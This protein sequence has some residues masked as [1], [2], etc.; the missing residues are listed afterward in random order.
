MTVTAGPDRGKTFVVQGP[1]ARLG[2]DVTCEMCLTDT[3]IS[4]CHGT[5]ERTIG[6]GVVI[7]SDHSRNG[8]YYVQRNSTQ[9]TSTSES[10]EAIVVP[11]QCVCVILFYFLRQLTK[12][13]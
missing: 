5:V 12:A 4:R 8:T 7:F 1:Y 9:P 10:V 2:R 3:I 11:V 13:P 6:L